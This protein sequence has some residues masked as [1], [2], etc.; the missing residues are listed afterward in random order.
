MTDQALQFP[1]YVPSAVRKYLEKLL[2]E[3]VGCE[4]TLRPWERM[5]PEDVAC[6]KR[7]AFDPRMKEA[8]NLLEKVLT[9]VWQWTGF[10]RTA[11]GARMKFEDFRKS[12]KQL[13]TDKEASAKEFRRI[14]KLLNNP[15]T[16]ETAEAIRSNLD[17]AQLQKLII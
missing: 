6:I 10:I 14:A 17:A 9:E 8:Y 1:T 3:C 13:A 7:L 15:L 11:W 12:R 4:D 16:D 2:S 5:D